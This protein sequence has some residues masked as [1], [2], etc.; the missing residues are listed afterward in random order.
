MSLPNVSSDLV[1]E[2]VRS[3]NSF[4]V[5]SKVSGGVQFSRDPFNL[6]NLHNRKVR[7]QWNWNR[8]YTSLEW[9]LIWIAARRF[10]QREGIILS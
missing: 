7:E 3:Q 4:L 8:K 10:R 1:W 5:K 6:T 9:E 2:I